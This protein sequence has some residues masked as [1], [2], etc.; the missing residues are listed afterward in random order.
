MA[1]AAEEPL[2]ESAPPAPAASRPPRPDRRL[3]RIG[4]GALVFILLYYGHNAKT[5]DPVETALGLL[6]IFLAVLP[7]LLWAKQ[8]D[9]RYPIFEIFLLTTANVYAIPLLNGHEMVR[10]F[11][12]EI[13]TSS[14][15][16]IVLYQVA[17]I[18]T[19]RAVRGQAKTTSFWT[20]DILSERAA[21]YLA[22]GMLVNTVYIV[23]STFYDIIP[24][25]LSGI[26][27]AVCSGIGIL[28]AFVT[29]RT[30]GMGNLTGD[31][32]AFFAINLALQ[33]IFQMV[34]LYL[35]SSISLLLLGLLGYVSASR[36]LPVLCIAVLLPLIALLHN[37]KSAMR[38]KYWAEGVNPIPALAEVPAFYTEWISDG[39]NPPTQSGE[40]NDAGAMTER[41]LQRT[42][43]FHLM[44][45]VVEASPDN[46]PFLD[47]ETYQ[48]I[49][50]QLIPRPL[51]P[52]KPNALAGTY[53]LA[54]YY[55][56]QT[57]ESAQKT[58]IGFGML[59]EAYANFGFYG[60]VGL[61]VLFGFMFKKVQVWTQHSPI[62][63]YPGLFLV[64]LVAWS[65]QTEFTLSVWISSMFQAAVAIVGIPFV[66]QKFFS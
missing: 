50:I 19:Y 53:R 21:S 38:E 31:K 56:L 28:C 60:L 43:L 55:G 46:V 20:Q 22:Y 52:D 34:S 32:K 30:W 29:M 9:T 58:S 24:A 8:G 6:I 45:L 11:R 4:S 23:V 35:V 10:G 62:F 57:E 16:A 61:G 54:I 5:T 48:D 65:F 1:D 49:L 27:R 12:E 47:G 64:L 7:S 63:S 42:S 25:D 44:C 3:F 18:V 59:T 36:R 37:G 13:V 39:L 15:F 66:L 26:M 40:T 14:A 17:A 2:E 41:L 33:V 51:W